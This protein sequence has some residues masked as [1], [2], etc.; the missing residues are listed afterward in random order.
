[1]HHI[2]TVVMCKGCLQR[3]SPHPQQTKDQC[4][5]AWS[6]CIS[7]KYIRLPKHVSNC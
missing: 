2:F 4:R 5:L 7:Q 6:V 3:N 1:M